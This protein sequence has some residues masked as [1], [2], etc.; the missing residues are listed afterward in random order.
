MGQ[1][2]V[3]KNDPDAGIVEL[4]WALKKEKGELRTRARIRVEG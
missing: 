3:E 1:L 4:Q 2:L